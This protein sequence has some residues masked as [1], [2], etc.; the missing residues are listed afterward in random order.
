VKK[1]AEMKTWV[2]KSRL[3]AAKTMA[4]KTVVM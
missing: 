1:T 2:S 4:P 3:E